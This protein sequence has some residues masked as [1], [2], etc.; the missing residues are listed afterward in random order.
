MAKRWS[1]VTR[2]G[3]TVSDC[4]LSAVTLLWQDANASISASPALFE[5]VI[6]I[7]P[8][9]IQPEICWHHFQREPFKP[10]SIRQPV[11]IK[12][13][14]HSNRRS[15]WYLAWAPPPN[16]VY[17]TPQAGLFKF[18]T[19]HSPRWRHAYVVVLLFDLGWF[20]S[21]FQGCFFYPKCSKIWRAD[22]VKMAATCRIIHWETQSAGKGLLVPC[23]HAPWRILFVRT[24]RRM[25]RSDEF[26]NTKDNLWG[27]V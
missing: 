6:M 12:E 18:K 19:P 17:L 23:S 15:V 2:T 20:V 16:P 4:S 7:K 25:H 8:F 10:W 14:R 24:C 9:I 13:E 27:L 1:Y 3:G 26:R 22:V 21:Q 11:P 5:A